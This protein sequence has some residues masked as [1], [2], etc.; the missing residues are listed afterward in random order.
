[1]SDKPLP[2]AELPLLDK[3]GTLLRGA[4]LQFKHWDA[5]GA[6]GKYP[7]GALKR[8]RQQLQ[9][10]RV[11]RNE[12]DR[13]LNY[14]GGYDFG[15][16]DVP[17][18]DAVDMARAYQLADYMT[19]F[20]PNLEA[21]AQADYDENVAGVF[22]ANADKE[23]GRQLSQK[24]RDQKALRWAKDNFASGGTV[25]TT[26]RTGVL[27]RYMET[28]PQRQAEAARKAS[29]MSKSGGERWQPEYEVEPALEAP[30]ISPDDLIGSGIPTK[31]A[32]LAKGLSPLA[33][34]G[35]VIKNKG[36]NWLEGSVEG[37][38]KGLKQHA[39]P[40]G[41]P[42]I[43][44]HDRAASINSWIDKALTRYVRNDMA[45]PEDPI[46][47]L[48]ERGV[49][50]YTP[51]RVPDASVDRG[52]A[53]DLTN[54]AVG[55]RMGKSP[56]AQDWEDITD[57]GIKP[58]T[59]E[60]ARSPYAL[61][62]KSS[63][64]NMERV[65][66]NAIV[67]ELDS[68]NADLGFN[69]LIDELSNSI[70]PESGLPRHLQFPADR[71]D[72]VSVPQAVERVSA[73]NAWRSAMKAEADAAKANNAATVMHKEYPEQGMKWVELR[74][75]DETQDLTSMA[76][77]EAMGRM[78]SRDQALQDA[79]KYEGDTMGHCVGG[80]CDDV[81]SGRSRIYSL[82]DAKG[83]PH[84]TVEVKP[85]GISMPDQIDRLD[86]LVGINTPT[87]ARMY[88]EVGDEKDPMEYLQWVAANHPGNTQRQN[89]KDFLAEVNSKSPSIVQ[90]KGKQ[91]RAPNP[92]YLPMVQDF[93]KSGK[94]SDVGDLQNTG[95]AKHPKT[96]DWIT[97]EELDTYENTPFDWTNNQEFASGGSVRPNKIET[98]A[99]LS[100][101]IRAIQS[102][103]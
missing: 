6:H 86:D 64:M 67:H 2:L 36:G 59:M 93:V 97:K 15:A 47:A 41:N 63:L 69:H 52:L 11:N 43:P 77:E 4:G 75:P 39:G 84:V 55:Q 9:L 19:T 12:I 20:D 99:D 50:H 51:G 65:H 14:G 22:A 82:R 5:S 17:L 101:I 21:D 30:M 102:G 79:L 85:S 54:G 31:L 13:A 70:N 96:G 66:D 34:I 24:E 103:N 81:A 8:F 28:Q 38:L 45:T 83:Q 49:L 35:G 72:K 61:M 71:L 62:P 25:N 27:T 16:R 88:S 95:L 76:P 57:T 100:A 87:E 42:V 58:M 89:A 91:N 23:L 90:I 33:M 56:L 37:A 40:M 10:P 80:Y 94:W 32:M 60:Y 48:A 73:I 74:S 98:V 18:K 92:E 44:L 78:K 26:P 7:E 1:M 3:F 29:V 46:R 68:L 53:A